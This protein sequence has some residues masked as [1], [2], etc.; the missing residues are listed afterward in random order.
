MTIKVLI[1]TTKMTET[2]SNGW[3]ERTYTY[4]YKILGIDGFWSSDMRWAVAY[5]NLFTARGEE[6]YEEALEIGRASMD[7]RAEEQITLNVKGIARDRMRIIE[8]GRAVEV[9]C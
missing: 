9:A 5:D 1:T 7:T 4:R 8:M 2:I 6:N 3:M